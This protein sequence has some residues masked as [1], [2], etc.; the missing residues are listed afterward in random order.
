ML[1]VC[2]DS[3][4]SAGG[5][6]ALS[7]FPEWRLFLSGAVRRDVFVDPRKDCLMGT[8]AVTRMYNR[9]A[10]LAVVLRHPYALPTPA[11]SA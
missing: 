9:R 5:R 1:V 7:T 10:M 11:E 3:A 6:R 8:F 4:S 2:A